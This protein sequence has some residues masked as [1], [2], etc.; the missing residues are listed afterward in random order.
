MDN[1][2]FYVDMF[3]EEDNELYKNEIDNAHAY[4]WLKD[5]IPLFSCPDKDL[6]RTYY[7][8][9]WTYRKHLKKNKRRIRRN[10][11]PSVRSLGGRIQHDQRSVWLPSLRR[12][13]T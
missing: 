12:Q 6:E 3:N 2:K 7:F 4:E 1:L 13:M 8:R 11:I 9:Y 10:R 5:E